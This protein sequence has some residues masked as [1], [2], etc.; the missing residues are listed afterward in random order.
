MFTKPPPSPAPT[1]LN[2]CLG[3]PRTSYVRR[4]TFH[5]ILPDLVVIL[6]S[7]AP[8]SGM[9]PLSL[10]IT[11]FASSALSSASLSSSSSFELNA[12]KELPVELS[13]AQMSGDGA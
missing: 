8:G 4:S 9:D 5:T 13:P 11:E 1:R 12:S 10:D 3:L 2:S 6:P 7:P